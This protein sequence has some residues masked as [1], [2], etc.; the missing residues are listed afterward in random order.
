MWRVMHMFLLGAALTE[1]QAS[2]RDFLPLS[3]TTPPLP[4]DAF[5]T[6]YLP[7]DVV[8]AERQEEK[9]IDFEIQLYKR[10][11]LCSAAPS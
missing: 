1:W 10:M 2:H 6:W 5:G 4:D 3:G 11:L 9:G 7:D 8:S